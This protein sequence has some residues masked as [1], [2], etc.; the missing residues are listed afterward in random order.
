M[1]V[2]KERSDLK[3]EVGYFSPGGYWCKLVVVE[4]IREAILLISLLNG[5]AGNLDSINLIVE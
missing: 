4:S 1:Y 5:G 3:Y 2:H